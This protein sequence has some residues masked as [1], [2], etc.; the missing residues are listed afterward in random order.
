MKHTLLWENLRRTKAIVAL[1]FSRLGMGLR[2]EMT[3]EKSLARR[4][5]S[6]LDT[7]GGLVTTTLGADGC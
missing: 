4:K 3:F 2:L 6:R 1:L 5:R 7:K